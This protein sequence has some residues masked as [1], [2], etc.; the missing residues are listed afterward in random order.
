MGSRGRHGGRAKGSDVSAPDE[1]PSG[2]SEASPYDDWVFWP[3]VEGRRSAARKEFDELPAKAQGE[4]ADR[5]KRVLDGTTRSQ[6]VNNSIRGAIREL[7]VRLGNNHYRILFFTHGRVCV[8][9]TC[10]YK[11]QQRLEKDDIDR[12]E[13]RMKSYKRGG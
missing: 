6:D 3:N 12:A 11:N 7:R 13:S 8:A 1:P 5:M 10:F 9:L 4:L 2:E